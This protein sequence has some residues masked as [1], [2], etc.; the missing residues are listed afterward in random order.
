MRGTTSAGTSTAVVAVAVLVAL[1][2][3]SSRAEAGSLVAGAPNPASN[4]L[5][6]AVLPDSCVPR[7][8]GAACEQAS[9]AALDKARAVMGL[10]PYV[11]PRGF[12]GLEPIEQVFVLIDLDRIAY[13][14]RPIVGLNTILDQAAQTGM[15]AD[16]DPGPPGNLPGGGYW[17]ADFAGGPLNALLA[18]YAWMFDDG[19]GSE[20]VD[21]T[22]PTSPG[23]WVH[24]QV[25]LAFGASAS[26]AMGAAFGR[27]AAR[28]SAYALGIVDAARPLACF[29]TWA[30]AVRAGA[31]AHAG[32]G[33]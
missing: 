32:P 7:P 28:R 6:H 1:C 2:F 12:Y 10:K 17:A 13:G 27:D 21:C 18:Y 22:S 5:V 23:C 29:Y 16:A 25:I 31:G 3:A 11:L 14:E 26:V 33:A 15:R 4:I 9:V 19:Y 8:D 24:R 20:N 30:D